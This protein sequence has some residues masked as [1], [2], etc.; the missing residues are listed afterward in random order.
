M[1]KIAWNICYSFFLCYV[2]VCGIVVTGKPVKQL[3]EIGNDI[4]AFL[5]SLHSTACA[6]DNLSQSENNV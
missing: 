1:I 3:F 4:V 6:I 2:T 5:P